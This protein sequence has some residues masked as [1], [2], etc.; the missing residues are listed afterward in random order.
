MNLLIK[1]FRYL[2]FKEIAYLLM[3][4]I[5]QRLNSL[6]PKNVISLN[7]VISK[8]LNLGGQIERRKNQIIIELEKFY[9]FLRVNSSDIQVFDQI[10]LGGGMSRIIELLRELKIQNPFILDC[11]ANIG[12]TIIVLKKSFPDATIAAIEPEANNFKQLEKNVNENNIK[13]ISLLQI[14]VWY[15]SAILEPKLNFRDK[16]DWSYALQESQSN[17]PGGIPVENPLIIAN[18]LGWEKID[19]IKI[20]I[21]GSEFPLL[22][23]YKEWKSILDTIKLISIEVHEELG[24]VAEIEQVLHMNNFRTE[25]F[26]ELIIGV[27][28][29]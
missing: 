6:V 13:D 18:K 9:Y 14:G 28:N 20:D 3:Y 21:E 15:K 2:N 16:K 4:I 7:Y 26:Q 11:G 29:E 22:R 17:R 27:R 10:V 24:S 19:Y 25:T 8:T 5:A 1:F 12:M 23:N